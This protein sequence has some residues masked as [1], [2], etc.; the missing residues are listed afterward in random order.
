MHVDG[1]TRQVGHGAR[2][3]L[4]SEMIPM[5]FP[6]FSTDEASHRTILWVGEVN[7]T[8]SAVANARPRIGWA[9]PFA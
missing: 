3:P 2:G 8:G 7:V 6:S 1:L 4:I 9:Y 5:K